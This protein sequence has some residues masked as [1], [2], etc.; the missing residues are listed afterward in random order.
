[1]IDS[2]EFMI[3]N[4]VLY[5]GIPVQVTRISPNAITVSGMSVGTR[6]E[7]LTP[8]PLT[9]E[10]LGKI[11]GFE[12]SGDNEHWFIGHFGFC[13]WYDG[14]DWCM[15]PR[16]NDHLVIAYCQH[17]HQLQNLFFSLTQT[18]LKIEL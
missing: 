1:M 3:G 18:E 6:L 13:L 11:E 12:K 15:K 17:L 9:D 5:N 7:D 14:Q 4:W 8:I 16:I 10:V 2:K